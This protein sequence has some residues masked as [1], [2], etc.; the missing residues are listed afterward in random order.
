M[1]INLLFA[2][3]GTTA[4][5]NFEEAVPVRGFFDAAPT[6]LPSLLDM[7]VTCRKTSTVTTGI[8]N[9]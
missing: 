8:Q 6:G 1:P 4:T 9:R 2:A 5:D 7:G 3:V